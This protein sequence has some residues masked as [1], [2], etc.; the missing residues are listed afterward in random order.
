MYACHFKHGR[1]WRKYVGL[2]VVPSGMSVKQALADRKRRLLDPPKGV[3][4]VAWMRGAGFKR[5]SLGMESLEVCTSWKEG[6]AQEAMEAAK[7]MV[8]CRKKLLP[9]TKKRNE[10]LICTKESQK[11][12]AE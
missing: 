5:D 9:A 8:C 1:D 3:K 10:K 4:R 7:L 12:S 6:V 2:T 11:K